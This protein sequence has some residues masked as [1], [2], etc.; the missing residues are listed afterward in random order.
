MRSYT[1]ENILVLS[2]IE[3]HKKPRPPEKQFFRTDGAT[4]PK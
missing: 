1:D 3:I 2:N 4:V